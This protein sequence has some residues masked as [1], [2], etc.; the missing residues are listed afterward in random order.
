MQLADRIV[1]SVGGD[2]ASATKEAVQTAFTTA[3]E[4]GGASVDS[5][6][7]AL[8]SGVDGAGDILESMKKPRT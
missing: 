6:T 1:G 3:T 8:K 2:T 4:V 7:E 5:V